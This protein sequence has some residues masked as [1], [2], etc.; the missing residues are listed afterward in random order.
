MD[1]SYSNFDETFPRNILIC[2]ANDS[3]CGED[4]GSELSAL[5]NMSYS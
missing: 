3:F 4:I 5:V 1:M 2:G